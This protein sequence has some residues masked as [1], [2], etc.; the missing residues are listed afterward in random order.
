MGIG[1]ATVSQHQ[2]LHCFTRGLAGAA[3]RVLGKNRE[4]GETR[5]F[6]KRDRNLFVRREEMRYEGAVSLRGGGA[7]IGPSLERC[8]RALSLFC[9]NSASLGDTANWES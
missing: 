3:S 1:A 4:N 5:F 6:R 2:R 8:A 9:I 7:T